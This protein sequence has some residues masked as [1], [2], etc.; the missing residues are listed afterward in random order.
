MATRQDWI[1]LFS[2]TT[3]ATRVLAPQLG[4]LRAFITVN[5][6]PRQS[7]LAG[8]EQCH[9]LN[10]AEFHHRPR[11]GGKGVATTSKPLGMLARTSPVIA[12][13]R[14]GLEHL[15]RREVVMV[16]MEITAPAQHSQPFH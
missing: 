15:N 16:T 3:L 12:L 1:C 13:R 14:A 9:V 10:C 2:S 8:Y 7:A 5:C 6:R 11:S 4:D